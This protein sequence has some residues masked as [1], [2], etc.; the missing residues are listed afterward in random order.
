MCIY[1]TGNTRECWGCVGGGGVY[2]Y[3]GVG[4]TPPLNWVMWAAQRAHCG[5]LLSNMSDHSAEA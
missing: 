1:M 4:G 3:G 5:H 2:I